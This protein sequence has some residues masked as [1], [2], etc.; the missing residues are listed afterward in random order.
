M[1]VS[2]VDFPEPETNQH[3]SPHAAKR[4]QSRS[5]TPE[6]STKRP[7]LSTE[8]NVDATPTLG[9]PPQANPEVTESGPDKI[10]E[11]RQSNAQEERKRGRR[12]FGGILNALTQTPPDAQQK[13][14]LEVEKRQQEKAR[15]Q[16]AK[17]D[18]QRAQRLAK[19]KEVRIQEQAKFDE[20][21]VSVRTI[22][23]MK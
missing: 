17:A 16:Q 18:S 21:S 22:L 12:L 4:R 5:P 20:E 15:L 14:R 23:W 9:A 13:K 3:E 8:A 7:R 19:L 11:R 10:R 2:A 1:A 6:A